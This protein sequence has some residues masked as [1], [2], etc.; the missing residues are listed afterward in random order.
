LP[1]EFGQYGC[2]FWTAH[3]IPTKYLVGIAELVYGVPVMVS[4]FV[5]GTDEV[6]D[7]LTVVTLL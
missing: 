5:T 1:L 7:P 6:T 4:T 2:P 3:D